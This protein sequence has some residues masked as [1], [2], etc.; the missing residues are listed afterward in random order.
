MLNKV[1][2]NGLAAFL[3]FCMGIFIA[4][5]ISAFFNQSPTFQVYIFG[6]ILGLLPDIDVIYMFVHKGLVYGD[7][8]QESLMHR[9]IVIIPT[10]TLF[11][12]L[13][14]GNQWSLITFMCITWHYIHDTKILGGGNGLN[15]LWPF[16]KNNPFKSSHENWVENTWLRPSRKSAIEISL[17]FI[18]LLITM[19]L[20]LAMVAIIVYFFVIVTW[21]KKLTRSSN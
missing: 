16:T 11:A 3:D 21:C 13:L 5:T 4:H 1:L 19:K 18:L 9:P 12:N 7:H 20:Y 15:W 10:T 8:H 6:A 17:G 2:G 14:G